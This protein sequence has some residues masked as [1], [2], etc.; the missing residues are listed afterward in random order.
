MSLLVLNLDHL[1]RQIHILVAPTRVIGQIRFWLT[2]IILQGVS[3]ESYIWKIKIEYF[4]RRLFLSTSNDFKYK[5]WNGHFLKMLAYNL[6]SAMEFKC[7]DLKNNIEHS[8]NSNFKI[9]WLNIFRHEPLNTKLIIH[10]ILLIIIVW[11]IN[12]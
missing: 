9:N 6:F 3:G 8:F 12:C 11:N 10:T 4:C 1:L 2:I 5:V 7:K